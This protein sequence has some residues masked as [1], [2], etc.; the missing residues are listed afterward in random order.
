MCIADCVEH[1]WISEQTQ[2]VTAAPTLLDDLRQLGAEPQRCQLG[3]D[4]WQNNLNMSITFE[5]GPRDTGKIAF[6]HSKDQYCQDEIECEMVWRTLP[7]HWLSETG[8]NSLLQKQYEKKSWIYCHFPSHCI[9]TAV[10]RSCRS[11]LDFLEE[12]FSVHMVS[13][14]AGSSSDLIGFFS[15]KSSWLIKKPE[16][17][18]KTTLLGK[19]RQ[20]SMSGLPS[21]Q[22]CCQM[23]FLILI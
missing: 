16:S 20:L 15:I 18:L 9:W 21:E 1:S 22:T 7:D 23:Q 17:H 11:S 5:Q 13:S 4:V 6:V 10:T 14:D 3:F 8:R 12:Q 19:C 2:D